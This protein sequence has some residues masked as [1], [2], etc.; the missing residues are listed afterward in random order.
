M[1]KLVIM[2][3][4]HSSGKTRWVNEN[5]LNAFS[6]GVDELRRKYN[7]PKL[8]VKSDFEYDT[9][10]DK[11]IWKNL[12][13]ILEFRMKNGE[14]TVVDADNLEVKKMNKYYQLAKQYNYELILCDLTNVTAREC[15]K[16]HEKSLKIDSVSISEED[17]D[18]QYERIN[19]MKNYVL[20]MVDS[21]V[22]EN[23]VDEIENGVW[24]DLST[25]KKIHHIGD[26][27]GCYEA[28]MT[29]LVGGKIKPDEAYVFLGDYTDRGTQSAEVVEFLMRLRNM[30][31]VFFL[32]GNHDIRLERFSRGRTVTGSEQF[33]K[34]RS[35][36][37]Q[38]INQDRICLRDMAEWTSRFRDALFYKYYDKQVYVTHG[39]LSAIPSFN[40]GVASRE[41]INGVG[42]REFDVD[43]A[44]Q[45]SVEYYGDENVIQIHGHRNRFKL[46]A[47]FY[48]NSINLEGRVE[49]GEFLRVCTLEK[50]DNGEVIIEEHHI[51]NNN[52]HS[53][54]KKPNL[55]F[56]DDDVNRMKTNFELAGV[57]KAYD[58]ERAYVN[59]EVEETDELP[60]DLEN[61]QSVI[62]ND[63]NYIVHR[64]QDRLYDIGKS[65]KTEL[66]NLAERLEFPVV[67]Y[68]KY[69]GLSVVKSSVDIGVKSE[70]I[71]VKEVRESFFEKL[72]DDQNA[73]MD[74][75]MA[76]NN[77]TLQFEFIKDT[78]DTVIQYGKD[79]YE[80]ILLDAVKNQVKF[81]TLPEMVVHEFVGEFNNLG[82]M[83]ILFKQLAVSLTTWSSFLRVY[84]DIKA[85]FEHFKGEG[86]IFEDAN[87]FRFSLDTNWYTLL[88][89]IHDGIRENGK[90]LPFKA[91]WFNDV[92]GSTI[93]GLREQ[94]K[95]LTDIL[96]SSQT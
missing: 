52:F 72:N 34:T 50:D 31:N 81:E 92:K 24:K 75:F 9:N 2:Y 33:N 15:K 91:S 21:V 67:A 4:A 20:G 66:V 47:L 22:G 88:S 35:E 93:L 11:R 53:F 28:L 85:D 89:G 95:A 14:F 71:K 23:F 79:E 59:Y 83:C 64:S 7:S 94:Y 76:D 56:H 80:V 78:L 37:N 57:E 40:N 27:H 25:Y 65:N 77:V 13:E 60:E 55:E 42:G 38:I 62:I 19:K 86:F 5:G 61:I 45:N 70:V 54:Y 18:M 46:P 12:F 96:E 10:H 36:I 69:D 82:K 74:K 30:P 26:I 48:R 6:I 87:G 3:G 32:M 58:Y 84:R 68:N 44:F 39:G 41:L 8:G 73:L 63:D 90:P 16:R 29:Y 1:R 51:Q 49:F 17:I 43:N